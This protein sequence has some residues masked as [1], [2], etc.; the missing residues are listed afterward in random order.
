MSH[1]LVRYGCAGGSEMGNGI[2]HV[3]RIPIDDGRDDEVQPGGAVLLR[4]MAAVD[5]SALPE[6]AYGLGEG[7]RLIVCALLMGF[8]SM[9]CAAMAAS[10]AC[11]AMATLQDYAEIMKSVPALT[12]PVTRFLPDDGTA[13]L[14]F[15]RVAG[16][17]GIQRTPARWPGRP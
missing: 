9:P 6:R 12:K 15:H 1:Q 17:A 14:Y 8:P 7:V 13:K 11:T 4:L 10:N 2:G 5:D 3:G 16:A